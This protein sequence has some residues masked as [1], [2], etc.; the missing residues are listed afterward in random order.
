[1]FSEYIENTVERT[2]SF[3]S[4]IIMRDFICS[5]IFSSNKKPKL[6]QTHEKKDVDLG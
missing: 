5:I 4:N 1:M 2:D 6:M 3:L